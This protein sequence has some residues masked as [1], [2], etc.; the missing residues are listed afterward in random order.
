VLEQKVLERTKELH[1]VQK[2]LEYA[3]TL[4]KNSQRIAISS[5][6]IAANKNGSG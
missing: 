5:M 1:E 6:H 2:Q 3:N 4:L